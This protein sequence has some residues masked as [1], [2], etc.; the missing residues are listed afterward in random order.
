MTT[1]RPVRA[2]DADQIVAL[3]LRAWEPVFASM[4]ST[5]GAD[6]FR[7]LFTD[8]WRRYQGDDIRRALSTYSVTVAEH[9]DQVVG[10]VAV[11]LPA[12][13]PH[14]EIYM[15]AVDPDF[16]RLGIGSRLTEH[17]IEEIRAAGR[18][19]VMVETGGDPGHAPARATYERLGFVG[20]P[21]ERYFLRL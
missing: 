13:E 14:G 20:L 15:V 1:L 12:G 18:E 8:D 5:V 17:A 16:H 11:D 4:E 10:Y 3:G 19:L 7:Q 2:D 6:L 21:A 9:G